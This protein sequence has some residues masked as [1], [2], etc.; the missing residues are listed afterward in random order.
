MHLF[1]QGGSVLGR[2]F[3]PY[4]AHIPYSLQFMIDYSLYGMNYVHYSAVKFR[5]NLKGSTS[6]QPVVDDMKPLSQNSNNSLSSLI[7]FVDPENIQESQL[8]PPQL[9]KLTLCELE[10]DVLASDI[11]LATKA[12]GTSRR[13]KLLFT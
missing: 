4:E 7:G 6:G 5:R 11:I 2:R 9:G 12:S 3:Q 13:E 8:G 1:L 10:I